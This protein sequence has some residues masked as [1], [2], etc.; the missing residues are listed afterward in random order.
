[1]NESGEVSIKFYIKGKNALK[2]K[3]AIKTLAQE[4]F[5]GNVSAMI[6]D[7]LKH[8]QRLDPETGEKL[9]GKSHKCC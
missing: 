5:R 7:A 8:V 6:L 9:S 2:T 3:R 4:T 1:M